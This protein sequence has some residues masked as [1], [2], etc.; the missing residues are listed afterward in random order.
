MSFPGATTRSFAIGMLWLATGGHAGRATAQKPDIAAAIDTYMNAGAKVGQFSSAI[1][2]ARRGEVVVSNGY[3][4]ANR[5]LDIPITPATVFR[6]ASAT[7]PFTATAIL[8][9]QDRGKLAVTDA[10]CKYLT[11][12]PPTW[13][14][15]TI[16]HLL[17]HT[18]G[19]P[20]IVT[21][22]DFESLKISPTAPAALVARIAA[23]PL[24]FA[25][26]AK[27]SY[28]NSGFILLGAIIER[29]SGVSYREFLKTNIFKVLDMSATDVDD[30]TDVIKHRA[31]G[32]ARRGGE[33]VNAPYVDMSVPFSA[34]SLHSTVEDL[35]TFTQAL[36]DGRLV[37]AK[38]LRAMTTPYLNDYGYGMMLRQEFG[39][40]YVG[41]SGVIE[42]FT[43]FM[44]R[45]PAEDLTI[46]VLSNLGDAPSVKIA[47]DLAAIVF[48]QPYE[49]IA[50]RQ[51]IAINPNVLDAYVGEY[52]RSPGRNLIIT[53][54]NDR[55][56]M[57][58][59]NRPTV[60][61]FAES[62]TKFFMKRVDVQI[63]FVTDAKGL[64]TQLIL[65]QLGED[66]PVKKVK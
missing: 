37:S 8:L 46:V 12:C 10:V 52:E 42:G 32:Y 33:P 26:G 11:P 54:K 40:P 5:E 16:H 29:V 20:D 63:T 4:M 15:L 23:R 43:S 18:G 66:I 44:A 14:A 17:S 30:A 28:S 58:F 31:A 55:L 2:V 45:Y 50:E 39:R 13:N 60:E 27:F 34:G 25:P 38:S 61:L 49:V 57:D 19:V 6:I 53:K 59:I 41:H 3:G 7:K 56:Y 21:F 9:L 47:H 65:H 24:D 36:L 1:L 64:V 62:E 48:G 22:P 51:A 35:Y